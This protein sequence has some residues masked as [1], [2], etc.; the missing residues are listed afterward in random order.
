[1]KTSNRGIELIKAHE[2]FSSRAYLCPAGKWTI[3]Y[4]HTG[5]VKSGDVITEAQG[6]ALLRSDIATA[7][8]AVNKTG[9]KLTQNQF[10]ALVSF[11]FNVGTGNFN[12][13]TLLKSAKVSTN[14]PRIRQEFSR[15]I[16]ADGKIEPGLVKRRKT[17]ADLY[18]SK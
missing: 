7:E 10:D 12:R 3:G 6:E 18:F 8:R 17:E 9:L 5:G 16:Y 14:D 15:W 2:G 4:G 1:M 11:V 13:S